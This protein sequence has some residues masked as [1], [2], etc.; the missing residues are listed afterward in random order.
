MSSSGRRRQHHRGHPHPRQRALRRAGPEGRRAAVMVTRIWAARPRRVQTRGFAGAGRQA[1]GRTARPRCRWCPTGSMP[2]AGRA[3][4]V[5]MLEN[6]RLNKGEKKNNGAGE[7]D[8]RAVRHLRAR[9]L[10]HRAPRRGLHL[11]HREFARSPAPA[12]CWPPRSTPSRALANPGGRWWRSSRAPRSATK[13]TILQALAAKV[14]QLIV[15]GGIANTFMLAA[16][17]PIGNSLAE[18][19]LVEGDAGR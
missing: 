17:L 6:C 10:R 2:T 12:H 1:H 16:G 13:L 14:D 9:R 7:E 18:P 5:V 4:A 8:G 15:G 3:R 11:R 19:A